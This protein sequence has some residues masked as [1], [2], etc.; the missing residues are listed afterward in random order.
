MP[1]LIR[2]K[3]LDTVELSGY[4]NRSFAGGANAINTNFTYYNNNFNISDS[5]LNVVN[6][7]SSVTGVLPTVSNGLIFNIKNIGNGLLTITGSANIDEVD[8]VSIQK[9]ESIELLGVNNLYYSGWVTITSN[10][11]ISI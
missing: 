8:S 2:L 3:Q 10:P 1:N 6:R 4:I 7:S 5:Y 9:N 11:G